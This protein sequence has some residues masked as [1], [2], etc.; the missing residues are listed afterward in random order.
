MHK[1]KEIKKKIQ[2]A[3]LKWMEIEEET[4]RISLQLKV[5]ISN[6]KE[7][8]KNLLEEIRVNIEDLL[9]Y[10][11]CRALAKVCKGFLEKILVISEKLRVSYVSP[12]Y[13]ESYYIFDTLR[14][15]DR[16]GNY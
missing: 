14:L 8:L 9:T 11:H 5:N 16:L 7:K 2:L 10:S 13:V 3:Q 15:T 1:L 4:A 6:R 12:G